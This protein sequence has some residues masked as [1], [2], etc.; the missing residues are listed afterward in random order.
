MAANLKQIR[1]ALKATLV[2]YY[3]SHGVSIQVYD[4]VPGAIVS[5]AVVVEP[6]SG[7]YQQTLGA[8]DRTQHM[9]AVTALV[10]TADVEAAQD[11]LDQIIS[12]V[13][14][15]S[16]AAGILSDQTLGGVVEWANAS[17]YRDYGTVSYANANYLKAT[18]DVQTFGVS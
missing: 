11:T 3:A 2:A 14:S 9:L 7:E 6:A 18:V 17:G 12:A 13:G 8:I 16:I 5:P 15:M 10:A 4:R 1:A